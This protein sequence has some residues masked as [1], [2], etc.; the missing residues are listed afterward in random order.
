M[1]HPYIGSATSLTDILFSMPDFIC[2]NLMFKSSQHVLFY[3]T[4]SNSEYI[5]ATIA[6]KYVS[7]VCPGVV[8]A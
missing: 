6:T 3:C 8:G 4:I 1:C 2:K 5:F 7:Q